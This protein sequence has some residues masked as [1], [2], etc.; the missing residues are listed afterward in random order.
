MG[1]LPRD[2]RGDAVRET[3]VRCPC[4]PVYSTEAHFNGKSALDRAAGSGLGQ[5]QP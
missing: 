2:C 3:S 5:K 4:P 1:L